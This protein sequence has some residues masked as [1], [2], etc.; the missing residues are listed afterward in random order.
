M[1]DLGAIAGAATT[2][3]TGGVVFTSTALFTPVALG[4][5]QVQGQAV[6]MATG[7][8]T[9]R[10]TFSW[11]PSYNSEV[12]QEAK[13]REIRFGDGYAAREQD[14]INNL[15]EVW[16]LR[17]VNR[18]PSEVDDIIDF[19]KDHKGVTPFFWAPPGKTTRQ[20]VCQKWKRNKAS[21]GGEE[22]TVTFEE[23]FTP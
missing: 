22:L 15:P 2:A 7:S 11:V 8:G 18:S 21:F 5:I 3:Y 19:L 4:L 14:G 1:A 12:D 23:D 17:F 9:A 6:P 20:F 13:V 16:S 10:L